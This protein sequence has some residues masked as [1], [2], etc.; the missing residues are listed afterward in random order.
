MK[1]KSVRMVAVFCL[2]LPMFSACSGSEASPS[3]DNGK[4]DGQETDVD[5]GGPDCSD[6]T[7]G[8]ECT[9]WSDCA[10]KFCDSGTGACAAC[11]ADQDCTA[12]TPDTDCVNGICTQRDLKSKGEECGAG[13]ECQSD[14]CI[15]GY[16]CDSAC[17]DGD[18]ADCQSCGLAG[19]EGTC[20]ELADESACG[21][22]AT[23]ECDQA[24]TCLAGICVVNFE[25][26]T[27][28]C[29]DGLT[30][31][32]CQPND[33]CDGAGA[34]TNA[35]PAAD[36]TACGNTDDTECDK[37]DSC[38][39]GVCVDNFAPATTACADGL[40]EAECQPNDR[41][42]GAGGCT[43]A[44]PVAD[45][46]ACGNADDTVCD[47]PDSC[48][49]GICVDNF[50]PATTACAEGL[51]EPECQ[52]NDRCDGQGACTNAAAANDD[53][54]CGNATDTEC[55]KADSCLT[56]VCVDNFEPATTA[57]ADGLAEPECQPNDLCDGQGACTNAAAANDDTTC[58]D[59]TDTECDK[60]DSCLTGVCVDNFEPVTTA[61]ADGLAEPE[62][63]P[64][65][66]CDGQGACTD[67]APAAK[68]TV[69]G[70][71]ADTECD[72]ADSCLAG[73]C[74][75]NFEPI[76]TACADGLA[77]PACQPND[78][79]DGQGACTDADAADDDSTCGDAT[80]T[81]CDK[82]DS[83]LTGVCVDNFEPA[84]TTCGDGVAEPACQPDDRCDGNGSCTDGAEA[85]NDSACGDITDTD[86]DN[87]DT[88]Q[89][90]VCEQ[91]FEPTST[92]CADGVAEPDCQP[93]D[94]CDGQGSCTDTDP[95]P[96]QDPCGDANGTDCDN[97]DTCLA[98]ECKDNFEPQTTLCGD[99][100]AE[101]I[102]QPNDLC[103]GN[104]GCIDEDPAADLT[105][106]GDD[107]L[108]CNGDESCSAGVCSG[109]GDP[110]AAALPIAACD[111]WVDQC[112]ANVWINEIHYD[113][114][115]NDVDEAVEIAGFAATDLSGWT[116]QFYNGSGGTLYGVVDLGALGSIP[117]QDDGFGT[118]KVIG[119]AIQNGSP[120]GIALV[121][122]VGTVIQFLS[123]EGS[124]EANDGPA[125]GLLSV[126]IEVMEPKDTPEGMSLQ[127]FGNG[128]QYND[129]TWEPVPITST[130]DLPNAGQDFLP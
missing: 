104:G 109:E 94:R 119:P 50:E 61:C 92:A 18:S 97:P 1:Y 26:A 111:E 69:C 122:G 71:A 37:P 102:C 83:C 48:L 125:A 46:T 74:V 29:G 73:V 59:A 15:D 22:E 16:C 57:C 67:A 78:L 101:P 44:D 39:A 128:R 7:S 126:D 45:D 66:L 3:C 115:G 9:Q 65:D 42:D 86:C 6:C 129:F 12:A 34:C 79:C 127:L 41:C 23:S 98:G 124:F 81:E 43:D 60:A 103:D 17:G 58:G 51:A 130:F 114:D 30:E 82:A 13:T 108:F 64:N 52:P 55:D 11:I 77:E 113:N 19:N 36:D 68:D 31:A 91:N 80:D 54:S 105:P 85:I 116:L 10:S 87:P 4:L 112:Q 72:K 99:G 53:T 96:D 70:D 35:D 21:D 25:P 106:C 47:N 84:T 2:A 121:D 75:D 117:N 56:G 28:A 93:D 100:L 123:Y 32:E 5:C 63:Q 120:D 40:T 62:C 110:C 95:A 24:D 49:A 90:G 118:L 88:C 27:T 107:G 89:A 20:S 14:H 8:A 76:T 33:R 38:L